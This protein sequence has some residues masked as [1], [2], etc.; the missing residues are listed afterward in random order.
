[1]RSLLLIVLVSS[2]FCQIMS[3]EV[4]EK[5]NF[6]EIALEGPSKGNPFMDVELTAVFSQSD[7][8]VRVR[9]FYDGDGIYKIRFM[10]KYEGP[11]Q[12]VTHS[13]HDNLH[14]KSGGFTCIPPGR[15]NHGP[16][17]VQ[18][19]FHFAHADGTP[20]YPV[21]TTIYALTQMSD[22][23]IDQSIETLKNSPF[24]KLRLLVF[25]K[26]WN[27]FI[28]HDPPD[29]PFLG[30]KEEGWDF[31]RF[32]PSYFQRLDR[33]I[34]SLH[35]LGI[36]VDL[37]LFHGYDWG[38]WGFDKM[39]LDTDLKYLQ[40][41]LARVSAYQNIW[42]SMANEYEILGDHTTEVWE[43][44]AQYV[45]DHDPYDHLRSIHN[46]STFYDH[47]KPWITHLS[48]QNHKTSRI[49]EW[50]EKYHKPV[51]VD[52]CS[53]EGDIEYS[54][55]DITGE[56]MV[57]RFWKGYTSGGYVTHGE[58]FMN[59]DT[60]MFWAEGGNLVGESPSRI[61]F[62]KKIMEEG[63]AGGI[64]PLPY[65]PSWNRKF[66]AGVDPDYFLHYFG[67]GQPKQRTVSLPEDGVFSIEVIDAWNMTIN[68]LPGTYSGIVKVPLPG[69]PYIGLR[70]KRVKK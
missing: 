65:E 52:E 47:S 41:L 27:Y 38:K 11:W 43:E 16:V 58:V 46:A 9:G 26:Q 23:I 36:Q 29:F 19:G 57:N 53:Y 54:W 67:E 1:M 3:E 12:Y 13:N 39:P 32:N 35:D 4:V 56:E 21:G 63:P 48:V 55:G 40:Y 68:Q 31:T 20:Y 50:R 30:S 61:A 7:K 42:W 28:N 24:N 33:T 15:E 51:I 66:K 44:L 2:A 69:T 25:P 17:N 49:K 62:L 6:F 60:L 37:I 18:N 5:W 14:G 8:S 64:D 34:S 10:P 59:V 22:E 45:V 70:I